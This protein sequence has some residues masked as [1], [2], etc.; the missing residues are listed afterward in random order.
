MKSIKTIYVLENLRSL[1]PSDGF[2]SLK[3]GYCSYIIQV[4]RKCRMSNFATH[5]QMLDT[6]ALRALRHILARE[7]F[8]N[9]DLGNKLYNT[10]SDEERIQNEVD[11]KMRK[12][13]AIDREIRARSSRTKAA[14]TAS[15]KRKASKTPS[16]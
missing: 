11:D 5:L 1:S 9:V 3:C 15:K 12:I 14:P 8:E 7:M 16:K 6:S 4:A 2:H 13:H 10:V